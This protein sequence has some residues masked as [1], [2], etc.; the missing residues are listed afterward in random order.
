[1]QYLIV[2]GEMNTLQMALPH[3]LHI[4]FYV[5]V[6]ARQK[7]VLVDWRRHCIVFVYIL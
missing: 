6:T 1:M 5:S 4:R 7:D 2:Q 3:F